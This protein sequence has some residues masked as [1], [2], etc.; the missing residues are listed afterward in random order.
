MEPASA[1]APP[2]AHDLR[3]RVRSVLERR[4]LRDDVSAAQA[5][6]SWEQD[7]FVARARALFYARLM[8]LTLGLL[9]LAV[10][11]WSGYFG[12]GSP[13]AL[14]GYL[15][16]LLYGVANYLVIDHPKAGRYVTY[17]T[18]C[19]DLLFMVFVVVKPQSG[20]GLQ[21]PLLATQLLFTTLFVILFPR[22]LAILPPLL[23]LPI[24]TQLD[25]LLYRHVTAVELLT[26][27]WYSGLNFIVVY[28]VVYLNERETAAHREVVAL[29]G[30]LK[31]LAV[32]EERNRMARDIHDGLGATLSSLIIQSEYLLQ[33]AQEDTL[34]REI[35]ELKGSAEEAI[36]ELR[37]SLQMMRED[38]ELDRG[39][40]DYV[41]TF[42]ERTQ[43]TIGFEAQG[44]QARLPSDVQLALFRILQECL[45]NAAKHAR[46]G[47]IDVRLEYTRT[48]VHLSV[49][50]DGC[51]F[52][53]SATRHGH[54]GLRNMRERAMKLGGEL[55]LESAPGRGTCLLLSLPLPA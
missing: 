30:D 20:G 16:M 12:L 44:P 18:L 41:K 33:L 23:A 37:R 46:A 11:E 13:F 35:S 52:D 36:E 48:S 55:A 9:I 19:F 3:A 38:F 28:V 43:L 31:E 2:P 5:A 29:Q 22:P 7:R 54:Y 39:L 42:G 8:F 6:A 27:L 49:R 51:G 4:R 32:V 14:A 17:V 26:V 45:A 15:T 25:L 53:P 10:P 47:R 21:S 24:T 50:D 34:R 1:L 40:G